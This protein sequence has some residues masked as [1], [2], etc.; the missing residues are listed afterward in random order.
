MIG[1]TFIMKSRGAQIKV[2]NL[3]IQTPSRMT[4]CEL[5]VPT[6]NEC[7]VT[8]WTAQV[9]STMVQNEIVQF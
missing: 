8:E 4:I 1:I 5:N 9:Y 3:T 6:N 2:F 7:R